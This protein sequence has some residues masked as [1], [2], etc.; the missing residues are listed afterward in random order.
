VNGWGHPRVCKTHAHTYMHTYTQTHTHI[1]TYTPYVCTRTRKPTHTHSQTHT[2]THAHAHACMHSCACTCSLTHTR[3]LSFLALQDIRGP[4]DLPRGSFSGSMQAP[5][6]TQ[7]RFPQRPSRVRNARAPH[8]IG[9]GGTPMRVTAWQPPPPVDTLPRYAVHLLWQRGRAEVQMGI[10]RRVQLQCA[11]EKPVQ[12]APPA[13]A[14]PFGS[15][16]QV[17]HALP[18]LV[19]SGCTTLAAWRQLV[20]PSI[21]APAHTALPA[22]AAPGARRQQA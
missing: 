5:P 4:A 16:S 19:Q 11:V 2:R 3:T 15:H 21:I 22:R 7:M 1:H 14:P 20:P 13:S 12:L 18:R 10:K 8:G 17:Q 9:S 6:P